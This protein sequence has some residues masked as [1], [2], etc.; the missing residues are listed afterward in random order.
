[1]PVIFGNMYTSTIASTYLTRIKNTSVRALYTGAPHTQLLKSDVGATPVTPAAAGFLVIVL[2]GRQDDAGVLL[3]QVVAVPPAH[4]HD[5]P[6]PG[7][8]RA[9][10]R[11]ADAAVRFGSHAARDPGEP[12][13]DHLVR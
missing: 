9:G 5:G 13:N 6:L 2:I 11:P 12:R 10:R 4:L 3:V 1:M 7:R 8:S